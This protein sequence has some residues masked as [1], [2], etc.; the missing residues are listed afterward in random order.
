MMKCATPMKHNQGTTARKPKKNNKLRK[1]ILNSH[2]KR[3]T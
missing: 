1:Q 2:R 3:D